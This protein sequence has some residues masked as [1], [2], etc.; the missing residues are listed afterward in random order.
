MKDFN[1]SLKA[2]QTA[3]KEL[4][5]GRGSHTTA[6]LALDGLRERWRDLPEEERQ[7]ATGKAQK[8]AARLQAVRV[9]TRTGAD[10][11]QEPLRFY[12]GEKTPEG[13]L[14]WFGYDGF[15]LGQ[16]EAVEA[17]LRGKDSLVVMPTGGG[18][19]L[20][21]QL[22]GIATDRLTVV[23]SPLVALIDDQYRRLRSEGHPAV[24]L[25]GERDNVA[26]LDAVKNGEARIVFAAP[27][28]FS[29]RAF[30]EAV[31][32]RPQAL[33]VVDE[34][35]CISEWGHDFRPDYLRLTK[36]LER[37]G[38]PPV[39]A[40]TA[41]ATPQV[42]EEIIARLGLEDPVIVRGGFDRPNLSF[43]VIPLAGKG[44]IE[45]KRQLLVSGLALEENRPAIV[46]CGTRKDTNEV[47]ELLVEAGVAARSYHAGLH[48]LDRQEAQNAFMAG[49]IDTIVATNAFGMGV[50]KADVRSVW[51]WALPTSLEAYYQEAGR[52]G[53][54]GDPARAVLLSLRADL[55][56]LMYF[57]RERSTS[58]EVV[59]AVVNKLTDR[60]DDG[61]VSLELPLDDETR[62]AL[63]VA[64]QADAVSLRPGTPGFIEV[65]IEG[66][67]NRMKAN[68][69][70]QVAKQRGWDAYR[71][72]ERF[73][74][75]EDLCH[76]RQL[77]D[78]F[79]DPAPGAPSGRCCSVC[80]PI[81]WLPALK[82]PQAPAKKTRKSG[83]G[84]QAAP[85]T[86][87]ELVGPLAESLKAWRKER[88]GDKPAYTVCQN[89]TL[90]DIIAIKPATKAELLEIS[91]I[92]EGFITKHAD[93][94]LEILAAA[95]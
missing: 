49:R 48:S 43:D 18:K 53:R 14:D 2:A 23:V 73:S 35:H 45:R 66:K 9:G 70:C 65:V 17:A 95:G 30:L 55:G 64:E 86:A 63:A 16:R 94:L 84:A 72:V 1:R 3:V 57:N 19:T 89:K 54:D 67:L 32:S 15:R 33:F 87:A 12:N 38:R 51:H 80:D 77:L 79:S 59:E 71:A 44:S 61:V 29:S 46:Y 5:A 13:L 93:S 52:A 83:Q 92:G 74:A 69:A 39:M 26:A 91:G 7:E 24:M 41:T 22:P 60:A 4:E 6:E 85:L 78:H 20:C 28:R 27:E 68:A 50:D 75:T 36:V 76:R 88:A 37:L 31:S 47:T 11:E 40:C 82:E 90:A 56:R 8:V 10:V 62:T 58:L 34:A 21:Y 42:A 81:D 25:A